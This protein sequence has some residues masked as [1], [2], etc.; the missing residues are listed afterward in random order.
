MSVA[1]FHHATDKQ[2]LEAVATLKQ[3]EE[4]AV[5][6]PN[7]KQHPTITA[8]ADLP[9]DLANLNLDQY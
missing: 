9:V 2:V 8:S 4:V 1:L 7:W 5:E 3:L 6:M